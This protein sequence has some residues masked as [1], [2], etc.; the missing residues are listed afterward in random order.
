MQI[1]GGTLPFFV[2][3]IAVA[4][5]IEA[6]PRVQPV[7]LIS[8]DRVG[9][10]PAGC[11]RCFEASVAPARVNIETLDVRLVDYRRAIHRHIYNA[12]PTS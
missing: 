3:H 1:R 10:T 5:P 8:R 4:K 9:K 6:K 12:A 2:D 11:R 7:G